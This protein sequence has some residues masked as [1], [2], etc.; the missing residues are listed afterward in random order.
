M[1]ASRRPLSG[2]LIFITVLDV[3]IP[4][5]EA[6]EQSFDFLYRQIANPALAVLVATLLM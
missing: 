5:P 4:E 2:F 6:S 1:I 3:L